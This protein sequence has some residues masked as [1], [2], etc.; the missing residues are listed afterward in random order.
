VC[1]VSLS[2]FV[3]CCIECRRSSYEKAV[4]WSACLSVCLSVKRVHFD[5][6]EE[7]SIQ[8]FKPYVR[9]FSLVFWE[10]EWLVGVTLSTWNFGSSWSH[11][12]EIADFQSIFARSAS[13][14]APSK[15]SWV[16]TN[17]KSTMCF[18][19]IVRW[20]SYVALNVA[21]KR[22]T[23]VFHLKSHFTW[24]KSAT[25]SLCENCQWQSFKAFIGLCICAKMILGGRPLLRENLADTDPPPC[26]TLIFYLFSLVVPQ[27]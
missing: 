12:S 25:N 11:W 13:E 20:T 8:I 19:V 24:R 15:K 14:M 17:S 23:A 18:P 3:P 4:F 27:P 10:E 21:R 5:K 2:W 16:N 6:T 1:P 22:K 9:A 7:K 26:E